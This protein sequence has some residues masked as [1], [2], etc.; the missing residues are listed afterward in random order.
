MKEFYHPT[1]DHETMLTAYRKWTDNQFSNEYCEENFLNFRGMRQAENIKN[2]LYEILGICNINLCKK[3]YGKD[4]NYQS[5]RDMEDTH[6]SLPPEYVRTL[7]R[8]ALATGFYF[9]SAKIMNNAE[10][11]LLLYPEGTVVTLDPTC[12]LSVQ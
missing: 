4:H 1:G 3:F 5:H 9:N 12:A 7:L 10:N 2:Q 11:Y 8:K 6:K